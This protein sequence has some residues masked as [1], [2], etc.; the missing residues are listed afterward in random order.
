MRKRTRSFEEKTSAN[1]NNCISNN[2]NS[3]VS[4]RRALSICKPVEELTLYNATHEFVDRT[5][6]QRLPGIVKNIIEKNKS[7][8]REKGRA[9]LAMTK[10]RLEELRQ[11][12]DENCY[13]GN[14]EIK[15]LDDLPQNQTWNDKYINGVKEKKLMEISTFFVENYFYRRIL[16]AVLYWE[17][18]VDPFT[19]HKKELLDSSYE[20][21]KIIFDHVSSYEKKTKASPNGNNPAGD[22]SN[23][24]VD[25]P[26]TTKKKLFFNLLHYQLWGNRVDLSLSGGVVENN[27]NSNNITNNADSTKTNVDPQSGTATIPIGT[28]I[29]NSPVSKKS[30]HVSLLVDDSQSVWNMLMNSNKDHK[31]AI[32]VLDNCGL[33]LLCDLLC[34]NT[35]LNNIIF[36]QI[37]LHCKSTPVFIS[38]ALSKDIEET[39]SWL[40]TN[41]FESL[42]SS[43]KAHLQ[44]NKLI[45]IDEIDFYTS[46]LPYAAMPK[47]LVQRFS[48]ADLVMIKGDANYRRLLGEKKWPMK[49]SFRDAL[50][51]FYDVNILAL[52]TLKWPLAVGL[53]EDTINRAKNLIG[54]DWDICG[55]CGTIQFAER[56]K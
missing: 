54:D 19:N 35:L 24:I 29:K 37:E 14:I 27:S 32:I 1:H 8:W 21:F 34:A 45:I 31:K 41:K 49:T 23:A 4:K 55:R 16:D 26:E 50:S 12:V 2:T 25:M 22:K 36:D 43:L 53:S 38:D 11:E 20:P 13:A 46:P 6:K 17:H 9:Y 48:D 52:R 30:E 28:I 5:V 44:N 42:S 47:V 3:P 15:Y 40:E 7:E 18:K 51:Y 56:K 10:M 33:E 39:I